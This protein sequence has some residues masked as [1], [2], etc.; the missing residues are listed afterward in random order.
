VKQYAYPILLM[1]AE[2]AFTVTIVAAIVLIVGPAFLGT[3]RRQRVGRS[4]PVT[5][6]FHR[7]VSSWPHAANFVQ[8]VGAGR[9]GKAAGESDRSKWSQSRRFSRSGGSA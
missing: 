7:H 3:R 4:L 1:V 2:T 6:K 9:P 5:D 8:G